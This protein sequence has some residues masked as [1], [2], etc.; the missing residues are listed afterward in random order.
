MTYLFI[1]SIFQKGKK[2]TDVLKHTWWYKEI[3]S[4]IDK[5]F[6]KDK[7]LETYENADFWFFDNLDLRGNIFHN[8]GYCLSG[9]NDI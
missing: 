1:M 6:N 4:D 5:K 7:E 8:E 2:P 9:C 3:I